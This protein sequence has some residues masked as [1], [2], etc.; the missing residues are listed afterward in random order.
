MSFQE[1][2]RYLGKEIATFTPSLSGKKKTSIEWTPREIAVPPVL[3]QE[4]AKRQIEEWEN[5]LFQSLT[6]AQR[7]LG[8]LQDRRGLSLETIKKHRLGL[9]PIDRWESADQWGLEP[10]LKDNGTPKKVWIPRGL[11]IPLYQGGR[12]LRLR[13]RRLK[14]DG[15][16]RYYFLRGSDTRAMILEN[17]K[18]VTVLVESELD[19]QLIQQEAGD[20]VNVVALGNA[21]TRPDQQTADLLNSSRLILVA[22]DSDSAGAKESWQWWRA[23]Y[24]QARRWPPVAGK[25][26]GDMLAAGVNLRSWIEVGISEYAGDVI[27][28]P[29]PEPQPFDLPAGVCFFQ[30]HCNAAEYREAALFCGEVGQTVLSLGACPLGWWHKTPEGFPLEGD[31]Q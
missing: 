23:H 11:T 13:I 15:D 3:W 28:Q 30:N 6:L 9:V 31:H 17:D 16:P 8:W 27:T 26:P 20:L 24:L 18:P 22:L 29:D 1:A 19:A 5:M 2:C 21:Q 14:S 7:M 4:K 25:D 10:V 12:V